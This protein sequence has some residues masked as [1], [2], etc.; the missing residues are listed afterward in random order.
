MKISR[1]IFAGMFALAITASFAFKSS[2]HGRNDFIQSVTGWDNDE[3]TECD[4]DLVADDNC[5]LG[6]KGPQCSAFINPAEGYTPAY[7]GGEF[8]PCTYPLYKPIK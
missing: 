4:S 2:S 5:A 7:A 6:N 1:M 3:P 8:A